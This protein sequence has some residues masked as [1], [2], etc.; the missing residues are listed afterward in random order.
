MKVKRG[1]NTVV[2]KTE[3]ILAKVAQESHTATWARANETLK[4]KE[5]E[6][7]LTIQEKDLRIKELEL[8]SKQNQPLDEIPSDILGAED[9]NTLVSEIKCSK[10]DWFSNWRDLGY[11]LG[12]TAD[13]LEKIDQKHRKHLYYLL[14][15]WVQWYPGDSRGSTKFPT[16]SGLQSALVRSGLGGA[17]CHMTPYK[18]LIT[19]RPQKI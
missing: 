11:Q 16:Y 7:T 15:G 14:H 8:E 17:I 4:A 10:S 19:D 2:L 1:R 3:K 12:F 6:L 5:R 18:K 13:E 9:M